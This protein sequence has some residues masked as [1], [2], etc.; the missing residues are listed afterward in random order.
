MLTHTVDNTVNTGFSVFNKP[1]DADGEGI[2]VVIVW[3]DGE[4]ELWVVE[5]ADGLS[6][7]VKFYRAEWG[8]REI[9]LTV[10]TKA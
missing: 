1:T 7:L 3:F 9:P 10:L 6:Q 2:L 8:D 4:P 5:G